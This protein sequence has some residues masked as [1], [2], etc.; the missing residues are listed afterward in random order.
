MTLTTGVT[1]WIAWAAAGAPIPGETESGDGYLVLPREQRTV[2]AVMDGLGHGPE[3]HE[4]TNAAIATIAQ[5]PDAPL[6]TWFEACNEALHRTRGVVMTIASIAKD[7]Q[8][9][10]LGVGNVEAIVVRSALP[11]QH[12]GV[13][14]RGG[15]VGWRLPSLR[16]RDSR[17]D[18][19]DLLVMATDGIRADFASSIDPTLAPDVI[20]SAILQQSGRGNDDALV[21]VARY[22][23]D[24]G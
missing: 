7:G 11:N 18:T 19:G 10:W 1:A 12:E 16:L 23:G 24:R 2:I 21:V 20:A 6:L 3:A 14:A 5:I 4:A 8:M 17:L 13:L 22:G 15:V 9:E